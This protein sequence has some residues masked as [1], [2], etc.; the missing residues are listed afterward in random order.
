MIKK[1]YL[2]MKTQFFLGQMTGS[3][4]KV[5]LYAQNFGLIR[6]CPAFCALFT[7]SMFSNCRHKAHKI[8]S[9]YR[10]SNKRGNYKINVLS[11][12]IFSGTKLTISKIFK[13]LYCFA[14]K[15]TVKETSL[16][17]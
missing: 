3:K 5:F 10:C 12:S 4:E 16:Q 1:I 11:Y 15:K 13:L 6:F 9:Y 17:T 2:K 8:Y 7:K 14:D